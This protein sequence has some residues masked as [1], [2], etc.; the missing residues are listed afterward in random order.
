MSAAAKDF[1]VKINMTP[2]AYLAQR[3][4]WP[5]WSVGLL[6]LCSAMGVVYTKHVNRHFYTELQQLRNERDRLHV[7]WTQLLL[8]RGT[9]GSDMRVEKIARDELGMVFPSPEKTVMIKP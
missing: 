2:Y 5:L 3:R 4:M 7:E 8:E 6:V 1:S 9:L